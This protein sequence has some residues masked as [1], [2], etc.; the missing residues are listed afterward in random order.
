[1]PVQL[2]LDDE[3]NAIWTGLHDSATGLV[4]RI[5]TLVTRGLN[6]LV[7]PFGSVALEDTGVGDG[8]I[9]VLD[10]QGDLALSVIPTL[11]TFRFSGQPDPGLIPNLDASKILIDAGTTSAHQA[12]NR[13]ASAQVPQIPAAAITSGTVDPERLPGGAS[14][15]TTNAIG[16]I[17]GT[18]DVQAYSVDTGTGGALQGPPPPVPYNMR[19]VFNVT[20]SS[21]SGRT[22]TLKMRDVS[23][24]PS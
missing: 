22:L 19:Q 18:W 11:P 23:L 13:M 10:A 2:N 9:P 8:D 5:H 3:L 4:G 20:G 12:I 14:S 21:L 24:S 17:T 7:N 6:S 16:T 1:M 15:V